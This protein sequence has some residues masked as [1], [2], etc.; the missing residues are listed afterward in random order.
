MIGE[1]HSYRIDAFKGK[2]FPVIGLAKLVFGMPFI[3]AL[4]LPITLLDALASLYQT[5]CFPLYRIPRIERGQ[6]MQ[7]RRSG[8]EALNIVDRLNCYYCS[9][10]NGVLRYVQ[11]IAAETERMWCPI[12]Q[13]QKKNYTPP[14]HHADFSENGTRESLEQYYARYELEL[15]ATPPA[16]EKQG[17]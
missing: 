1:H 13:M 12:R 10:A 4:I 16:P 7:I 9:Y 2:L 5:V 17:G 6:F 11:K 14:A 15:E 3:Y 8:L